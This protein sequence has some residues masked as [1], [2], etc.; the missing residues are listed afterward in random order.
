MKICANPQCGRPLTPKPYE[1]TRLELFAKRRFCTHQCQQKHG[2]NKARAPEYR[3]WDKM[4]QRCCNPQSNSYCRYGARGIMV[5]ER[6]RRSYADFLADVGRKPTP[7]H[8]LDRIDNDGH[9][10]PGNVRWATRSEQGRNT[11]TNRHITIGGVTR[12]LAEW[13]EL[14]GLSGP[15]IPYRIRMGWPESEWLRPAQIQRRNQR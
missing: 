14:T 15:T 8:S 7:A 6:W 10:A 1:L 2:D 4:I 12:T 11:R 3:T 13:C 9:Y 5:C